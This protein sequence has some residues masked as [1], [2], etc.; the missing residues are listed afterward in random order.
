VATAI[1][2]QRGFYGV[3]MMPRLFWKTGHASL[4]VTGDRIDGDQSTSDNR[5]V[6][7]RAH[8]NPIKSDRQ[9]LHLG[10]WGFDER[11]LGARTC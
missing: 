11:C 2:P 10:I 1:I 7:A 9:V 6:L 4:T 8:W 3:G 5:T